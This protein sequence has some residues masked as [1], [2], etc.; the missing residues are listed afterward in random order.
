MK[1]DE[2]FDEYQLTM[3]SNMGAVGK[4]IEDEELGRIIQYDCPT[5]GGNSGG[6]AVTPDGIVRGVHTWGLN[7]GDKT[8]KNKINGAGLLLPMR[9]EIDGAVGTSKVNWVDN[10]DKK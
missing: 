9:G 6:P 4:I 3:N 8:A 1:I 10:P 2:A 7:A 5:A